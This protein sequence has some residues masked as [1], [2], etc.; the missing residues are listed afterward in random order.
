MSILDLTNLVMVIGLLA[1]ALVSGISAYMVFNTLDDDLLGDICFST[2]TL[3]S[4]G[5]AI[6]GIY[7]GFYWF[8]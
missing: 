8:W 5:C 7:A 6:G 1:V 2:L 4:L 3:L